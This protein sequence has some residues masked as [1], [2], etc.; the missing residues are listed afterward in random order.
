MH[1]TNVDVEEMHNTDVGV[2]TGVMDADDH[3]P[4]QSILGDASISSR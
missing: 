2:A 1:D 4:A 3:E